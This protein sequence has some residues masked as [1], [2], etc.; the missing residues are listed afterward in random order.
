[1]GIILGIDPGATTGLAW[2]DETGEVSG[3]RWS[4]ITGDEIEQTNK[5]R[6]KIRKL[7]AVKYVVC[8]SSD[9]FLLRQ[10][11]ALRKDALIPIRLE[12]MLR[13]VVGMQKDMAYY[14]QQ[15]GQAKG[16]MTVQRLKN[17]GIEMKHKDR[18]ARDAVRHVLLFQRRLQNKEVT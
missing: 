15:P 16:V 17:M 3:V 14:L 4:Q 10:G 2:M 6:R 1:M 5:I 12:A 11:T 7:E 9:Y 8:E 13:Y 18:H